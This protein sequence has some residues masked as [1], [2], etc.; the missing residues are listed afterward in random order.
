MRSSSLCLLYRSGVRTFTR[1]NDLCAICLDEYEE[2]DQLKI[3]P[4]SHTYHCKCIDP[5]FSQAARRSCPVYIH[6]AATQKCGRL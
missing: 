4:C 3:L 2:G 5:W 6:P 1:R